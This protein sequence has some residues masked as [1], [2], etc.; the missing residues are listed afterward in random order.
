MRPTIILFPAAGPLAPGL[1]HSRVL[2]VAALIAWLVTASIGAYMARAWIAGGGLRRHRAGRDELPP[3]VVL[4]HASLAVTG[5]LVWAGYQAVGW[6]VLAWSAVALMTA[7][8]GLGISTVTLL[9]P[10]PVRQPGGPGAAE[11]SPPGPG[12]RRDPGPGHVPPGAPALGVDAGEGSAFE[13]TDEMLAALLTSP[14]PARRRPG[15]NLAALIPVVHGAGAITTFLL[16]VLTVVG[17]M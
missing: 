6:T 7:A 1:T 4:A 17:T 14:P 12:S 15:L 3:A 5:L 2:G 10:Y 11:A 9:T 8:I 13:I 16:A